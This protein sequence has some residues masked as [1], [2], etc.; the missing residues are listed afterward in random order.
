MDCQHDRAVCGLWLEPGWKPAA[1][2]GHDLLLSVLHDQLWHD[3]G[4]GDSEPGGRDSSDATRRVSDFIFVVGLHL[5]G[6]Q[7]SAAAALAVLYRAHALLPRSHSRC[8]SARRWLGRGLAGA[9]RSGI[10]GRLLFLARLVGDER[11]AD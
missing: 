4:S 9:I 2:A 3:A 1:A 8:F 11:Y 5:S 10:A 6:R 7:H